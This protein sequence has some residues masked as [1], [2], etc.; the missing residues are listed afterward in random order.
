[1]KR[2][3]LQ[4]RKILIES[5]HSVSTVK[6][7]Q[8][9]GYSAALESLHQK[10]SN[11]IPAIKSAGDVLIE[12]KAASVNPID[13]A[14]GAGYGQ[15]VLRLMRLSSN[16]CRPE[17]ITYDKFPLTLGRDFSGTVVKK[18][19]Q[20]SHLKLGDKVWGVL[21]PAAI[22]GSHSNYVTASQCHMSLKPKNLTDVEAASI[23]YA[24]LTAYSAITFFGG[25]NE[26]TAPNARVLVLGGT[27][28]VGSLA[29]QILKAWGSYVA[30][31][32]SENAFEW[33]KAK[34]G[35]DHLIDYKSN[36]LNSFADTFDFVLDAG[37]PQGNAINEEAL[38]TL[39]KWTNGK[40]VTLSSP[41]LRN[42]D[43]SGYI[44]G[45]A[46]SAC[47]M[48]ADTLSGL[49]DGVSVRWAYFMPSNAALDDL[50][51]LAEQG[52][53]KPVIDEVFNFDQVPQS[54]E[55]VKLG[56]AR[57]KTVITMEE[58]SNSAPKNSQESSS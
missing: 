6:R 12:V 18:G 10:E 38:R 56:H 14:I 28:G 5:K 46:K 49:R 1:M 16:Q 37:P 43:E 9:N 17:E 45:T 36:E 24:G 39:R 3:L 53:L 51:V 34:T 33:L 50:R 8:I 22:R 4:S 54:Y 32:C 21:S 7:W 29:I 31:T 57:G 42:L 26:R 2:T 35:V 19:A 52:K 41:L 20:V 48:A 25:I 30:A 55:K 27:G 15:N 23:P 13:V 40:Y 47:M 58:R 11:E 44:F